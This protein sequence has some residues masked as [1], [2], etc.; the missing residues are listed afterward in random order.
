MCNHFCDNLDSLVSKQFEMKTSFSASVLLTLITFFP[1]LSHFLCVQLFL[2]FH[3]TKN[4]FQG[5]TFS[6]R[7]LS[8]SILK[9]QI[10]C[11]VA[12]G[13]NKE[14]LMYREIR[15]MRR[16]TGIYID[17]F[18]MA[19]AKA[20]WKNRVCSQSQKRNNNFISQSRTIWKNEWSFNFAFQY[21]KKIWH[22][23]PFVFLKF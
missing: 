18:W 11:K 6:F 9:T 10:S 7:P 19:P 17:K 1:T 3:K 8:P 4:I 14:R 21:V 23:K 12:N 15:Q 16:N 20:D 5:M 13:P 22:R 2:H